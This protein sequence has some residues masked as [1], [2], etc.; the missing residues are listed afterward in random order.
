MSVLTQYL[1]SMA[2]HAAYMAEM[3][4]KVAGS[5]WI[6]TLN[7]KEWPVMLCDESLPPKPFQQIRRSPLEIPAI[8]LG[9]RR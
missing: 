1:P 2:S 5:T 6:V 8:Q 9:R 4:P 3:H 7:G